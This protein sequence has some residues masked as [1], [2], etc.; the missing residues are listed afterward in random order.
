MHNRKSG[1]YLA[2]INGILFSIILTLNLK[3]WSTAS[4]QRRPATSQ[5]LC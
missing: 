1:P 5:A 3:P 2:A 4:T